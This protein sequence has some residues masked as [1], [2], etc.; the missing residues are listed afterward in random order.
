[1]DFKQILVNQV[2]KPKGKL[3]KII[4]R[5]M[6]RGHSKL[7]IWGISHISIESTNI[8]LDIGCGG[9]SNIKRFA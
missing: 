5:G 8:I 4:A 9:G 3:G 2:R 7:A 1:M 6:N